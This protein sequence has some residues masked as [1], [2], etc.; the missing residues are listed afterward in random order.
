MYVELQRLGAGFSVKSGRRAVCSRGLV[1]VDTAEDAFRQLSGRAN[2]HGCKAGGPM[3][4]H[5]FESR[6][7]M[8]AIFTL[9]VCELPELLNK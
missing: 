5:A 7:F 4:N 8:V 9:C 2:G 6:A 1:D 3:R